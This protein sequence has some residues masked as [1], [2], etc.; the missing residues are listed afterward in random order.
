ML[1]QMPDAHLFFSLCKC[2]TIF[3]CFFGSRPRVSSRVTLCV[4][5]CVCVCVRVCVRVRVRVCVCMFVCVCVSVSIISNSEDHRRA[6]PLHIFFRMCW[7]ALRLVSLVWSQEQITTIEKDSPES[8]I[9]LFYIVNVLSP[10]LHPSPEQ[11]C[12]LPL[13][14]RVLSTWYNIW[15]FVGS[16]PDIF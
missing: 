8:G 12:A 11:N 5:V 4:C 2:G 6:L 9:H 7:R 10:V 14:H 16:R 15:C 1:Y 13:N 3:C